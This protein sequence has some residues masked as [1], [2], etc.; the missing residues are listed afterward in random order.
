M[1]FRSTASLGPGLL[2]TA[3]LAQAKCQLVQL[4][5]LHV[6]V[7]GNRPV[8]AGQVNGQ[9]VKVLIDTGTSVSFVWESAAR[10]LG[11]PLASVR[12]VK[13]FGVGGEATVQGTTVRELQVGSYSARDVSL[14]VLDR[15]RAVGPDDP[16]V[17]LGN[18]FFSQSAAEFDLAQG[19]IRLLRPS[20]CQT[21]DL[22]YWSHTY[23][24]AEL[25]RPRGDDPQIRLSV[26]INGRPVDAVLDTGART[27]VITQAAA[28]SA[29][30]VPAPHGG[31]APGSQGK[32]GGV[33]AS[34]V[35]AWTGMLSSFAIGDETVR[36]AKVRVADLFRSDTVAETGSHIA[37]Q[38]DGLPG[39]LL[40]CDF[41]LSH[42]LMIL[43]DERK[44]VFTY[45]GGP[46][47]QAP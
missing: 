23:S 37:R 13:V 1:K 35:P 3:S 11:L 29:G 44:V 39:M 38:P 15:S 47:F 14:A 45:N 17:V 18:D 10:R 31:A 28:Q 24:L 5:E 9:P 26:S 30:V 12:S 42:R 34:S 40:G 16:A 43:P 6:S 22:A 32:L 19:S 4:G 36:S 7:S 21:D 46:V 33:G 25:A 2:L 27:S 8:V 20:G 41:F